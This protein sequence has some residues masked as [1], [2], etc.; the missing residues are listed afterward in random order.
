MPKRYFV[1]L[2]TGG[3]MILDASMSDVKQGH[4]EDI[5]AEAGFKE[6]DR[7]RYNRL[8]KLRM[9][10]ERAACREQER[11]QAI[12]EADECAN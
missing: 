3:H 7:V 6:V 12:R 5:V 2:E 1:N 10:G 4:F 8:S 11:E 9:I